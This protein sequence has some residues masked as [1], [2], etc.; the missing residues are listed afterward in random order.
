MTYWISQRYCKKRIAGKYVYS[1]FKIKIRSQSHE[2]SVCLPGREEK[3][4]QRDSKQLY[5]IQG[6]VNAE[7]CWFIRAYWLAELIPCVCIHNLYKTKLHMLTMYVNI[8][9]VHLGLKELV[10]ITVSPCKWC[11]HCLSKRNWLLWFK[12][13]SGRKGQILSMPINWKMKGAQISSLGGA[14]MKWVLHV[15]GARHPLQAL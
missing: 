14:T 3:E 10:D 15:V 5:V 11:E 13:C 1:G 2:I 9:S 8:N 12:D 7:P 4:S 6:I